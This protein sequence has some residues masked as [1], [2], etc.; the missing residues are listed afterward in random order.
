MLG[1]GTVTRAAKIV[2]DIAAVDPRQWEQ[3]DHEDNPFLSLAFLQALETSGSVTAATGWQPHHLCLYEGD[4]LVAFAPSYLKSHSHGEFV[5][6]WAWAD[7]YQRH[8]KTY[9]PKLLTAVPYSPVSGP[10]LLVCRDHPQAAALRMEL[11]DLARSQCEALGLSS[12]HCNFINESDFQTLQNE[13]LL[14]RSDWQFHWFNQ[15]YQSFDDF[16]ATLRSKKRKNIRRDRRLV[17][18]SGIRFVHKSGAEMS[19]ADLE[20][21]HACY[22]QTFFEHGNHPAL[23]HAFFTRLA[24]QSPQSLLAVLAL[25]GEEPLAMSLFLVGGGRLYGRYWGCIEQVPGLHFETT[26][27]QGIEYCIAHGLQV[28]EPGAQGEHKISRGFTPVRTHSFHLVRD[29]AYRAAIADF[30]QKEKLWL[31]QYRQELTAHEPFR[32]EVRQ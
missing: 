23:T 32:V 22:Q 11:V 10:R 7:A 16:L 30:L 24:A 13:S 15:G 31:E 20:F 18:Q 9:Y 5:F 29:P 28:F 26:Y 21:I 8:G 3:L 14:A 27:H 25:R 1:P 4:R 19:P 6:D 17:M 2:T 12:W